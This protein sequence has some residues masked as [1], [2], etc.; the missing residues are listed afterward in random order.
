[1]SAKQLLRIALVLLGAIALWG[2]LAVARRTREDRPARLVLPAIDSASVNRVDISKAPDSV[3]LAKTGSGWT[4][5]GFAAGPGFVSEFFGALADT[6]GASE[7][8]SQSPALHQRLGVD[9]AGRTLKFKVGDSTVATLVVGNRGPDFDG[10]Y[11]RRADQPEVYLVHAPWPDLASRGEADWRDKQVAHI[12]G[13]SIAGIEISHGNKRFALARKDGWKFTTEGPAPDSTAASRLVAAFS[14][15]HASG[16]PTASQSDSLRS[17]KPW[18][19]VRLTGAS[20][21]PLF[22]VVLDSTA[23]GYW[24]RADSGSVTY[25][26]DRFLVDAI[27]PAES[28]LVKKQ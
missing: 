22:S 14:D 13:D 20:G 11:V 3:M 21:A 1:M 25:R 10:Y 18:R 2:A 17:L 26:I 16:F 4:V 9:S 6:A 27:T 12:A 19:R 15:L 5:N 24:L 7:L 8:V 23:A 28:V